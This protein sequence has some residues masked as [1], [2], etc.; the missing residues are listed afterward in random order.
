M[1]IRN[2]LLGSVLG[3]VTLTGAVPAVAA[4][5]P[6][7]LPEPASVTG[8]I[9]AEDASDDRVLDPYQ[10][11]HPCRTRRLTDHPRCHP[12]RPH[13]CRTDRLADH[14][15]CHPDRPHPCRTDRLADHP[16]CHPD[17]PHPCRTDRLVDHPRCHPDRPH[18]CR[19]DRLVDH[20]RCSDVVL[21]PARD[22]VTDRTVD[23]RPV[24]DEPRTRPVDSVVKTDR[25]K[26]VVPDEVRASS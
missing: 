20:P 14:P 15:R 5:N 3:I 24:T 16:R 4:V 21:E 8:V 12:D 23:V 26:D 17:R 10:R 25:V 9:L 7:Q 19:T 11:P 22:R 18:P 1:I 6:A 13:P 2:W